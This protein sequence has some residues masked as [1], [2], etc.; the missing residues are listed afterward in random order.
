[1]DGT[2][3]E[4]KLREMLLE[5]IRH[6]HDGITACL[7][8]QAMPPLVHAQLALLERLYKAGGVLAEGSR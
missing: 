5:E 2:I 8:T 3:A 4:E 6:V 7:D 1:M